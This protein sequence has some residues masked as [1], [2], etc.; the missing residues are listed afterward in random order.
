M[1]IE[2]V[3]WQNK[4]APLIFETDDLSYEEID[5][6]LIAI[7]KARIDGKQMLERLQNLQ[8]LRARIGST[9]SVQELSRIGSF[10]DAQELSNRIEETI[11][12]CT[13]LHDA[14][15]SQQ[16]VIALKG[17]TPLKDALTPT[18]KPM[19]SLREL[20]VFNIQV[21]IT[22]FSS[23]FKELEAEYVRVQSEDDVGQQ[24]SQMIERAENSQ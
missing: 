20:E 15:L 21:A 10:T 8:K 13:K 12:S 14:L 6:R 3:R 5:K 22:D 17:V 16:A 2:I 1:E 9:S 4:L 11:A 24:I 7:E 23:S 19:G 18:E